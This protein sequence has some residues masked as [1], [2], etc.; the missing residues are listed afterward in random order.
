MRLERH[1]PHPTSSYSYSFSIKDLIGQFFVK[2]RCPICGAKLN[3]IE[4]T[5]REGIERNC[6][7]H[8]PGYEFA[9]YYMVNH[10]NIIYKCSDC[11]KEF[12]IEEL[13]HNK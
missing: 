1:D 4:R 11:K 12:T 5:T 13:L 3:K 10:V 2:K 7:G 9:D 8:K 6:S